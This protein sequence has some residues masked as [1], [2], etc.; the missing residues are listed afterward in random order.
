MNKNNYFKYLRNS[1][2]W[3]FHEL[4]TFFMII[5]CLVNILIKYR[6]PF[7]E[8]TIFVFDQLLN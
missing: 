7:V 1:I 2:N 3:N 5:I 6:L 8:L 4:G